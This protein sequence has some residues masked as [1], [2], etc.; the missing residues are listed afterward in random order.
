[1]LSS[2]DAVNVSIFAALYAVASLLTAYIPTG[3]FFIQFRPA[4]AIP[5]IA[6][7]MFSPIVAGLSAALGTFIASIAR[8][9]TPLLT[10]F[11]GTP[12]NFAGFCLMGFAYRRLRLRNV[13]WIYAIIL[14]SILGLFVGSI[15][16]A[17]GLWFLAM[18]LMPELGSFASL[19][20]ALQAS[21]LMVYAPAPI[22]I[23]LT[24]LIVK[25]LEKSGKISL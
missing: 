6:S 17:F 12:A 24:L 11:S 5:M 9:H 2:K 1:L 20:Y 22:S 4:I 3:P 21:F 10:I 18:T 15:I 16:I 7:V 19:D 14:S 8:Y 25:R 13:G 23:M